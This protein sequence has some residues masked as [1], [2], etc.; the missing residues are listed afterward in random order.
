MFSFSVQLLSESVTILKKI[1]RGIVI[2]VHRSPCKVP[3]IFR[4]IFSKLGVSR[5]NFGK[6]SYIKFHEVVTDGMKT[7]TVASRNYANASK[8]SYQCE[9]THHKAHVDCPG[10]KL[11]RPR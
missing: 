6:S 8:Y 1:Q 11:V 4:Q 3:V 10:I 2:N 9:F 7:L 5:Q